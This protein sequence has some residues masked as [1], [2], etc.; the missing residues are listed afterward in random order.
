LTSSFDAFGLSALKR[1]RK[2]SIANAANGTGEESKVRVFARLERQATVKK[3]QSTKKKLTT[4]MVNP[5][6]PLS[7]PGLPRPSSTARIPISN[8]DRLFIGIRGRI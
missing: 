7:L 3:M 4:N 1:S 5:P 8:F 2:A 6:T